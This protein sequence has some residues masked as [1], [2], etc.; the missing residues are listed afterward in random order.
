M[1]DVIAMLSSISNDVV[2][3]RRVSEITVLGRRS[4]SEY[5]VI[6][7]NVAIRSDENV[8]ISVATDVSTCELIIVI[9]DSITVNREDMLISDAWT[10]PNSV[11]RAS[12]LIDM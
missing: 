12:V 7:V 3:S 8:G 9:D 6:E 1:L 10:R 11:G 5:A 4:T 2:D